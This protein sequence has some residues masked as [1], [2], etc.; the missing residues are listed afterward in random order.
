M[1]HAVRQPVHMVNNLNTSVIAALREDQPI[2][3]SEATAGNLWHFLSHRNND[4]SM[5]ASAK[6]HMENFIQALSNIQPNYNTDIQGSQKVRKTSRNAI[7][8][9]LLYVVLLNEYPVWKDHERCWKQ[10]F[11]EKTDLMNLPVAHK[12]AQASW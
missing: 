8:I 2:E 4:S 10:T 1:V 11:K 9:E 3:A 5:C 7:P 12:C 6:L